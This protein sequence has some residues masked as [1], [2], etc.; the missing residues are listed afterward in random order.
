MMAWSRGLWVLPLLFLLAACG[1]GR[2]GALIDGAASV[3]LAG[4]LRLQ[5]QI[6]WTRRPPESGI[7]VWTVEGETLN[8]LEFL[9]GASRGDPLALE[10]PGV[11]LQG[12]LAGYDPQMTALE[13]HDLYRA[14]L[15]R[16][17]FS[18]IETRDIRPWQVA[19]RPGFRFEF[20]HKGGDGLARQ[21]IAV[22]FFDDRELWLIVYT[23]TSVHYFEKY[24]PQV[25]ALLSSM[26]LI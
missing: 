25:E 5:P 4:T 2:G 17:G 16:F 20:S 7:E 9:Q 23:A 24:R 26:T 3:T 19:G 13:V 6:A 10:P 18:R 21:G 1:G 14:T 12:E 15:S 8:K 11:E 22:G